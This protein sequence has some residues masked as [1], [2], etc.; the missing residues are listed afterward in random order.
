MKVENSTKNNQNLKIN[1][2]QKQMN[3]Y[4]PILFCPFCK[5]KKPQILDIK[6][7][8]TRN[9]IYIS[10]LCECINSP[11]I[12]S[13]Y[14]LF[15]IINKKSFSIYKCYKHKDKEGI[16][17]C[18]NCKYF[19]CDIC[20]DYHKDF[21]SDH[22]TIS[23]HL[24]NKNEEYCKIHTNQKNDLYCEICKNN[25]CSECQKKMHNGH[26][27]I[28]I[29]EYWKKISN[30]LKFSSVEELKGKLENER[31]NYEN[32]IINT[33]E[34]INY[35]VSKFDKLK[36]VI[37]E[38]YLLSIENH[39]ILSSIILS[40]FYEFFNKKSDPDFITVNN[41][42][43]FIP[44]N[45]ITID[46]CN[47]LGKIF[48]GF[49]D[50]FNNLTSY[51]SFI[52]SKN[53]VKIKELNEN[54]EQINKNEINNNNEG[55]INI[56]SNIGTIEHNNSTLSDSNK[57][58]FESYKKYLLLN[59]KIKNETFEK[60]KNNKKKIIKKKHH[61]FKIPLNEHTKKLADKTSFKFNNNIID[62]RTTNNIIVP[63]KMMKLS[64]KNKKDIINFDTVVCKKYIDSHSNDILET[65]S[66]NSLSQGFFDN[67]KFKD[68]KNIKKEI[69]NN[70]DL[71]NNNNKNDSNFFN[72]IFYNQNPKNNMELTDNSI[73]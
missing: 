5:N 45:L 37:Y 62:N 16:E 24:I 58:E 15:S 3:S 34:K 64:Q 29:K 13:L 71:N 12:I 53:L 20:K 46:E 27:V 31:K 67:S 52:I 60:E 14:E 43:T 73:Q 28:T 18:E 36:T 42:K 63:E 30:L 17:Y 7:D 72:N 35:L 54:D 59:K 68:D 57:K 50:L 4:I 8:L 41:C 10:L 65:F 38:S 6:K 61:I 32:I 39:K 40:V 69:P 44:I 23:T 21:V 48:Y 19:L 47:E 26:I 9:T 33:L 66:N 25:I 11:K 70:N 2:S 1:Q 56:N 49:S 22:K 51:E 55:T